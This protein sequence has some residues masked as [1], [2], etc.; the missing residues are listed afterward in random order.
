MQTK[1]VL[2]AL[3]FALLC[4]STAFGMGPRL[5]RLFSGAMRTKVALASGAAVGASPFVAHELTKKE[6]GKKDKQLSAQERDW[7]KQKKQRE[8]EAQARDRQIVRVLWEEKMKRELGTWHLWYMQRKISNQ[9]DSQAHGDNMA[10][11][12]PMPTPQEAREAKE[13][14]L[15][16]HLYHEWKQRNGKN[17]CCDN[18]N[19]KNRH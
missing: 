18:P 13:R 11:D 1:S 16:A 15:H 9:Y 17:C 2:T 14:I 3:S 6:S 7:K 19:C 8:K 5:G 10:N 4:S 12:Y